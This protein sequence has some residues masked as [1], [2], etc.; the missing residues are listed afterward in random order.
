MARPL[1]RLAIL[2]G[3]S[4]G[5]A[6]G[7]VLAPNCAQ[8]CT[9]VHNPDSARDVQSARE[10][11]RYLPGFR[12]P[13]NVSF[14]HDPEEGLRGAD[15][16]LIAIP[17]AFLRA[18]L[19]ELRHLLP[20]DAVLVNAT[21]GLEPGTL[22]RMS[23]VIAASTGFPA[24]RILSLSGPTF[25]LEV[26]RG[27][28]AAVVVA[29][30]KQPV[31]RIQKSFARP[32]FRVYSSEDLTGVELG[33][34]LKN[35]VAIGAGI[36]TGLGLGHNAVAA[37]ITRGLAEITRLAVAL[38]A[39]PRTLAGLAG[40]GDLVLT[41][42]GDLSRNRQLGIEL[43]Q[44]HSARE[45]LLRSTKTTEGVRTSGVAVELGKHFHVEMPIASE[46]CAVLESG[47]PPREAIQRLM[48]RS[49]KG[50]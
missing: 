29:G 17:S 19:A 13:D 10:N 34:A 42:T 18:A 40:L 39:Q 7:I 11:V 37:L 9:I 20:P 22:L 25:A 46:M 8:V 23:E 12:L 35:V 45:V 31:S 14:L 30:A 5:T 33:G 6:L 26:A 2:G 3:G 36:V 16:V 50:E 44:S 15:V 49:L 43:T 48:E 27:F 21:K 47:R 28:P 41:C 24:A 4:W 38:G 32:S 1:R